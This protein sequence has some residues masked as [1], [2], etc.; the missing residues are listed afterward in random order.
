MANYQWFVEPIGKYSRDVIVSALAETE[1]DGRVHEVREE[2]GRR[3]K[4]FQVDYA[5][6]S[7]LQEHARTDDDFRFRVYNRARNYG[8]V[9][10]PPE[11][12]RRHHGHPRT[13]ACT[14]RR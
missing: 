4:V 14:A 6:I 12:G 2:D 3:H 1:L 5:F 7:L 9:R 11:F 13:P 10:I 8:S